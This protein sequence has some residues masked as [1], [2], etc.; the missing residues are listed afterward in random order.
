MEIKEQ[1][2]NLNKTKNKHKQLGRTHTLS[3]KPT[4]KLCGWGGVGAEILTGSH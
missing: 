1:E 2:S 3:S 4:Q